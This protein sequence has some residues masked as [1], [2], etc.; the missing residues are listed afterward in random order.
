ME[1]TVDQYIV[2]APL[3]PIQFTSCGEDAPGYW[4]DHST[5]HFIS[6]DNLQQ[7][8]D[9]FRKLGVLVI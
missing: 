9:D 4:F 5:G 6:S 2:I 3:R 1:Q 8:L 7:K